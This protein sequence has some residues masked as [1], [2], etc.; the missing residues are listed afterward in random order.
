[1][2]FEAIPQQNTSS[3]RPKKVEFKAEDILPKVNEM[4][5]DPN[6]QEMYLKMKIAK[7]K[8]FAD[9]I[10]AKRLEDSKKEDALFETLKRAFPTYLAAV[11]EYGQ[12]EEDL[13]KNIDRLIENSVK[14]YRV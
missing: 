5:E 6:K 11:T 3:E 7:F 14:N 2:N 1:M 13:S 10:N 12:G 4:I 9:E 8:N